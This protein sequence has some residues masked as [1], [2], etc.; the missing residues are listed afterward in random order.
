M[1]IFYPQLVWKMAKA[2]KLVYTM[3]IIFVRWRLSVGIKRFTYLLTYIHTNH[4]I[5]RYPVPLFFSISLL[6]FKVLSST[7]TVREC[8][9]VIFNAF[10]IIFSPENKIP[11]IFLTVESP[12]GSFLA[13]R[14]R[15]WRPNKNHVSLLWCVLV[16]SD[17]WPIGGELCIFWIA[18]F[19]EL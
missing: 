11:S 16:V 5:R 2:E 10:W 3:F 13:E 19:W 7:A 15:S 6:P 17:L 9:E 18:F 12:C 4:W 1:Y 14:R 8:N